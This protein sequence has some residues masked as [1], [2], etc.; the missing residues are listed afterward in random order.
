MTRQNVSD[1]LLAQLRQVNGFDEGSSGSAVRHTHT[2]L[3]EG[4]DRAAIVLNSRFDKQRLTIGL[5]DQT[6]WY[7]EVECWFRHNN[8]IEQARA[9]SDI[10]VQNV[11]DRVKANATLGGSAFDCEVVSGIVEEENFVIGGKAFLL[12]TLTLKA[13]EVG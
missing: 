7:F 5:T 4:L 3:N 1:G 12:E 10:Y 11:L 8:D 2:V 9:D 13:T 6:D